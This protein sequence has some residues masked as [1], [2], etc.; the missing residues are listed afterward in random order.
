MK[1]APLPDTHTHTRTRTHSSWLTAGSNSDGSSRRRSQRRGA[2]RRSTRCGTEDKGRCSDR[3]RLR[4]ARGPASNPWGDLRDV[5]ICA[6]HACLS[7]RTGV[8]ILRNER[9]RSRRPAGAS[10]TPDGGGARGV[11]RTGRAPRRG[12]SVAPPP[13][14]VDNTP[15]WAGRVT[16]K[17][18]ALGPRSGRPSLT[19]RRGPGAHTRPWRSLPTRAWAPGRYPSRCRPGGYLFRSLEVF[20]FSSGASPPPPQAERTAPAHP[21]PASRPRLLVAPP[22]PAE[23]ARPYPLC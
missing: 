9:L 21:G 19:S 7:L 13:G 5:T 4:F 15:S 3:A 8:C 23:R 6:F 16:V 10:G 2:R 1:C 22:I 14:Q 20:H 12:P 11:G 18:S 17:L